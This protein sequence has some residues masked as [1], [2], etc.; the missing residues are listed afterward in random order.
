MCT[1]CGARRAQAERVA[2]V[3]RASLLAVRVRCLLPA[4]MLLL[5]GCAA[6]RGPAVLYFG[7]EDA[8]ASARTFFPQPPEVPRYLYV[9]QLLGEVNFRA[10]GA[11]ARSAAE[12][13]WRLVAGLDERD[14]K[15]T[16]LQRP[17]TGAV[18]EA[19]RIYVTDASRQAVFV[20]DENAGELLVWDKAQGLAGFGSPV[21]IAPGPRG[22]VYVADADLGVVVRLDRDGNPAGTIGKG[23]LR[24]P[25]GIAR[26]AVRGLLYVADTYAHDVKVFDDAGQLLR[27]IGRRGEENGEFNYPSHLAFARDKLYVTDTMN[28]R[29][30]V[31]GAGGEVFERSIGARGLYVGNLVRPKGVAVDNEGHVYVVESYYDHLLVFGRDG[32][33]LLPIGGTGHA[34]G[35]FFLPAGVWVDS[36][37]RVFVADMFNGR[38]VV[39]QFL[40]GG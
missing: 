34:A 25:A 12:R 20:F 36:R 27:V 3:R 38:V 6:E 24:R 30:Q 15:R 19:G 16:V 8:P 17:V 7:M 9:G 21:G 5:S 37:N 33:F 28:N 18:D 10:P 13:L 23:V 22:Q 11:E 1:A 29:V 35:S 32:E 26:D 40:G 31:F 4:V 14:A 2:F 39:F